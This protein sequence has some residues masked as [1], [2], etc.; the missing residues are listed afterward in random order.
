[1][2]LKNYEFNTHGVELGQFYASSAVISDGTPRPEPRRD[3]ELYYQ[4]STVPGSHLPHACVGD[5]RHTLAM[6]D[7]APYDAFTLITGIAGAQWEHA[8]R[9]VSQDLGVPIRSVVIG[10]GR[11]VNDLYYDWSK[12]REVQENGAILV[13]PDK[14]IGWRAMELPADPSGALRDAMAAILGLRVA[15]IA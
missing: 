14:F 10:P 4:P 11:P 3:P 1:M 12:L 2:D 9:E 7:I 5:S 15:A 8:A 13:R 6:M